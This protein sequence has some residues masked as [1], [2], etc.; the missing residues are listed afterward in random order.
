MKMHFS[1]DIRA[2]ITKGLKLYMQWFLHFKVVEPVRLGQNLF[3]KL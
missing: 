2:N 1:F 3:F